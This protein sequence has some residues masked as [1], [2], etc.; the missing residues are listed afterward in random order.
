[1]SWNSPVFV[2][3]FITSDASF[4]ENVFCFWILSNISPPVINSVTK[5][6]MIF[7]SADFSMKMSFK[8]IAE[9]LI[10]CLDLRVVN[11]EHISLRFSETLHQIRN[12][13]WKSTHAYWTKRQNKLILMQHIKRQIIEKLHRKWKSFY[14]FRS[15]LVSILIVMTKNLK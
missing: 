12:R 13:T 8:R 1:M 7:L 5:N 11:D 14:F 9:C 3:V 4:S 10:T 2:I 15:R 6:T